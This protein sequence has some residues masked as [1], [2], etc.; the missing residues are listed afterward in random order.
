MRGR[1]RACSFLLT[2]GLG[3]SLLSCASFSENVR[4][5]VQHYDAA[6]WD[7]ALSV[8]VEIEDDVPAQSRG[9][10]GEYY[11]YLALT[12]LRLG[13]SSDAR[14][15][16]AIARQF[17]GVLPRDLRTRIE[18]GEAELRRSP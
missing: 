10:R 12:H 6:R 16:F 14:H 4:R 15:Y 8:W 9:E 2:L 3:L 7:K 1:M 18:Q 13:H 5:G 17:W 11:T